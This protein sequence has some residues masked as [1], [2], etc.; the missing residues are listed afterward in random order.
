MVLIVGLGNPGTAYTQTR[1]NIGFRTIDAIANHYNLTW[2]SQK[3]IHDADCAKGESFLLLKPTTYM[4]HSGVAVKKALDYY[5][6]EPRLETIW[7]L[8]DELDLP[9]GTFKIHQDKSAAGHNG[10][11]SII[12]HLHSKEFTRWRIGI[13]RPEKTDLPT[14]EYVLQK[15]TNE[16]NTAIEQFLPIITKSVEYTIKHGLPKAINMYNSSL[17]HFSTPID[18]LHLMDDN[19]DNVSI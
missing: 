19:K 9:F 1:H 16:Q 3:S 11:Q 7:V 2:N 12:D 15:F 18:H 6:I 17:T 4:N 5:R 8:H 10:I 14:A 13:G